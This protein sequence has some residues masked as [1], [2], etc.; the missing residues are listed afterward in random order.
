MPAG[1]MSDVDP[2]DYLKE[3]LAQYIEE[4]IHTFDLK[5]SLDTIE[6]RIR[7]DQ[8]LEESRAI[9]EELDDLTLPQDYE[10]WRELHHRFS[11][12]HEK[13]DDLQGTA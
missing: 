10:R 4:R 12:V 3:T 13:I 5:R 9:S 8:L 7:V 6:R 1:F 11:E 2:R